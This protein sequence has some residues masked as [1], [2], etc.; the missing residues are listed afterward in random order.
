MP[1]RKKTSSSQSRGRI[2]QSKRAAAKGQRTLLHL[3]LPQDVVDGVDTLLW[4]RV[5][6]ASKSVDAIRGGKHQIYDEAVTAFLSQFERRP[7]RAL[8][9]RPANQGWR[10]LWVSSPLVERCKQVAE[11]EQVA[12]GRVVGY[13]LTS[14]IKGTIRP[15]WHAFRHEAHERATALLSAK[16]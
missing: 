4:L 11:R 5:T 14:F 6:G 13:A 10:T 12:V 7:C 15:D 1:N 16:Q 9:V 3:A 2:V 8:K